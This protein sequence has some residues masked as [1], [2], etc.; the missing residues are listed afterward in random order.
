MENLANIFGNLTRLKILSCLIN[1]PKNVTQLIKNCN[2]S[3][4]AV[5]QHL[6]KLRKLKLVKA[7]KKGREVYYQLTR[8]QAGKIAQQLLIFIKKI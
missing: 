8:K 3:Q 4:S 6:E 5:S 1:Q 7:E 2:L